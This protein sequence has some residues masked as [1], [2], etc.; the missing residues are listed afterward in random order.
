RTLIWEALMRRVAERPMTG[1]GFSAF[2]GVD[3]TPAREIR[4]ETQWPVPSAHN[5]WIDLL[6]QLGWPGAL[7]V[8]AVMLVSA[9]LVI[10]RLNGMGAREG[11]WSIAYLTVF[12]A[13]SL[14][15]SV[16]LTHANLPWILMLAIMSRAMTYDPIPVRAPL[17]RP[18]ARAYQNRSRIASDYVNGRR[19]LR[20]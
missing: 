16:L 5:G 9:I 6:V 13:L 8:G 4:L 12:T 10:V 20:F 3:S 14:S 18:A 2:W 7:F 19:P 15:E 1:Y 11:Y 17:A